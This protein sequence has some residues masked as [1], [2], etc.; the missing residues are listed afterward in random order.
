MA[1]T[2]TIAQSYVSGDTSISTSKAYTSGKKISIAESVGIGATDQ[3]HALVLDVTQIKAIIIRCDQD[4][5][6]KFNVA[7]T[8]NPEIFMKKDVPYIWTSDSY[9]SLILTADITKVF[10][11]ETSGIAGT[12]ELDTIIDPTL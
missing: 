3:E 10:V 7:G 2:A 4:M 11:T 1:K 8:P 12:F 9:D 5:T 6:L